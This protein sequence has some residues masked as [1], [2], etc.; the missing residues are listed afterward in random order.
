M[1]LKTERIH[2]TTLSYYLETKVLSTNAE[3]Y[4]QSLA[5]GTKELIGMI[6]TQY[7]IM[8]EQNV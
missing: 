8:T 1:D 2:K 3:A 5:Y 7:L 4:M 6:M